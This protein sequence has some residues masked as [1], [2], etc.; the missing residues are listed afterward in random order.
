MKRAALPLLLLAALLLSG[1]VQQE[2]EPSAPPLS[3]TSAPSFSPLPS[4]S[5]APT[6]EPTPD[7][8]PPPSPTPAPEPTP[9][10]SPLPDA[11]FDDAAFFG[12]SLTVSLMKY[13]LSSGDLGEAQFLGE[14]SLSLKDALGGGRLIWAGTRQLPLPEAAAACGAGKIFLLL[15][16]NDLAYYGGVDELM[17][18]WERLAALLREQ[19][20]DAVL[21]L[22]SAL[23]VYAGAEREGWNNALMDAYNQR[24]RSFCE[25][26]EGCVYVDLAP[27]LKDEHNCLDPDLC[28]DFFCHL[29]ADGLAVWVRELKD[30]SNYSVDPRSFDHD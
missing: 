6:S 19:C 20:P 21:F 23:P 1:C 5:P 7:P 9:D 22:E 29:T 3:E 24:L 16:N 2:A 14:Y 11:W 15:G 8:P 17:E 28:S 27:A 13:C 30:P 26:H 12:D 18:R 10:L 25:E 4:S